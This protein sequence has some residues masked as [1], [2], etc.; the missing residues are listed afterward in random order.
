M[1]PLYWVPTVIP[2]TLFM[3]FLSM[4]YSEWLDQDLVG[5]IQKKSPRT[6]FKL[7]FLVLEGTLA[8]CSLFNIPFIILRPD[9]YIAHF[10][11][12]S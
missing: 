8:N 11:P 12:K 5:R 9:K 2:F 1:G 4:L 7:G 6:I 3:R 10:V